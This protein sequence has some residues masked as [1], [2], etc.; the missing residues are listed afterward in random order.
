MKVE[1]KGRSTALRHS[2]TRL[3]KA[4]FFFRFRFPLR[5]LKIQSK[6]DGCM[7]HDGSGGKMFDH[8]FVSSSDKGSFDDCASAATLRT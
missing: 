8:G 7:K 6:N 2:E 4:D 3:P 5:V 1:S